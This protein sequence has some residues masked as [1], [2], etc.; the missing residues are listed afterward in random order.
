KNLVN[1]AKRD[2]IQESCFINNFKQE[3][4][5][6]TTRYYYENGQLKSES[7][8]KGGQLHGISKIYFEN[9]QLEKEKNYKD[10][11]QDGLWKVY[12]ENG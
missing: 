3:T 6:D 10:G 9:G 8:R 1:K 5:L 4:E 2:K 12:F 7:S 11:K